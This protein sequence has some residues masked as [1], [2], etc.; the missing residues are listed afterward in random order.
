MS[1][2]GDLARIATPFIATVNPVAAMAT[3][4]VARR[5]AKKEAEKKARRF[6]EE[7]IAKAKEMQESSMSFY[8]MPSRTVAT[9]T[10][11]PQPSFFN[12]V[13]GFFRDVGTDIFGTLREALP[14]VVTGKILG[15]GMQRTNQG[16]AVTTTL[17]LGAQESQSSGTTEAFMGSGLTQLASRLL[18]NPLGQIGLGTAAGGALSLVGSDGKTKRI[19][20]KMKSQARMLLN[21]TGNNPQMTAD[22]LNISVD[23]LVFILSKRFRND[24]PVVT[25]AALRKTKSTIRKLKNMCDMYDDLRPS[26]RRRTPMRRARTST[27][28]IKN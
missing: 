2:L 19:T 13:G 12:Q 6:Q 27:T 7:Q 11:P 28:L 16:P 15:Q 24:G 3:A 8:S 5:E 20:R 18:K 4:E 9:T 26:A 21:I 17:N 25:K 14:G 23:E 10:P 1:F 22:F